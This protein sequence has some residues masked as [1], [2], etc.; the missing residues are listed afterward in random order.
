MLSRWTPRPMRSGTAWERCCRLK[1][2]MMRQPNASWQHWSLKLAVPWSLLPSFPESFERA[3]WSTNFGL[4]SGWG[5][6][7]YQAAWWLVSLKNLSYRQQIKV[8]CRK[9]AKTVTWCNILMLDWEDKMASQ[10]QITHIAYIFALVVL[11]H[12][13]N[14]S[15]MMCHILLV[16]LECYIKL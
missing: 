16:I 6:P 11:K 3:S 5:N 13:Y 9:V 15:W 14:C 2:M 10:N 8:F 12:R 1:A 7:V 4:N